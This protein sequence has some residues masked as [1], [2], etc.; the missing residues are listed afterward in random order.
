MNL[1]GGVGAFETERVAKVGGTMGALSESRGWAGLDC[2]V[3]F[4]KFLNSSVNV[5]FLNL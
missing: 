2:L 5:D 3:P 1:L 4:L